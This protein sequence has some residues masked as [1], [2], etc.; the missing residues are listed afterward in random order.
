[1]MRAAI[2]GANTALN[3]FPAHDGVSEFRSPLTIMT[4]RPS[5]DYND[6]QIEFGAYAQVFEDKNPTN[7]AKARTMGAIALTPT[8]N[9]Q[10]GFY[11]LSLIT[12]RRLLRQQWDKF[13]MPDGVMA[14][15]KKMAEDE[16]QPLVGYG[17]PL[18][19]W[20]PGVAIEDEDPA[21]VLQEEHGDGNKPIFED[22]NV[23]EF[24]EV[25]DDD[26]NYDNT[27]ANHE[28]DE[29][30][31]EVLEVKDV[32]IESENKDK[33]DGEECLVEGP[34]EQTAPHLNKEIRRESGS[35]DDKSAEPTDVP[36]TTS[37][38]RYGLRPN[39]TRNYSNRFDHVMDEPAS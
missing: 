6:M 37:G 17:A 28:L 33:Q 7:T 25:P 19:E 22:E 30:D 29:T 10:G 27:E 2:E 16:G 18:F 14:A 9:A 1:M 8:G 39:R 20:S 11:F 36:H 5:P 38:S 4:G 21:P 23:Q 15:V 32:G 13:P 3:Q 31:E 12:G 34:N 26:N 24:E 35:G